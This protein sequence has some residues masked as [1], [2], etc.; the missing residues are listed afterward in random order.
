MSL[1][2]LWCLNIF[3]FS[4]NEKNQNNHLSFSHKKPKPYHEI[5][6]E[7]MDLV[8]FRQI[9]FFLYFNYF[10][11]LTIKILRHS[12]LRIFYKTP[13]VHMLWKIWPSYLTFSPSRFAWY[14][15]HIEKDTI[16]MP[17]FLCSSRNRHCICWASGNYFTSLMIFLCFSKTHWIINTLHLS[18]IC[19]YT[20]QISNDAYVQRN[21]C[22]AF[23]F[24]QTRYIEYVAIQ[25]S[26][27]LF[28]LFWIC[29]LS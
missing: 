1:V 22:I 8:P 25:I 17:H 19:H 27:N 2:N 13:C 12:F 18:S 9:T 23:S 15:T 16:N 11:T 29:K 10:H 7:E 20:S 5:W 3:N 4:I 26:T 28:T 14:F 24:T 6:I 21:N